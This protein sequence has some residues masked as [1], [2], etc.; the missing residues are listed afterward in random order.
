M[1]KKNRINQIMAFL[2]LFWIIIWVVWTG[3]LILFG[4]NNTPN[5]Q[6]VT[7]EEY[8]QIQE[9]IEAQSWVTINET[10][11]TLTWETK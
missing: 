2:A 1:T 5:E 9:I 6:T 8:L 4:G 10:I 11:E 7:A 3:L